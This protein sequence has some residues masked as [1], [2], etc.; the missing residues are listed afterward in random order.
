MSYKKDG[1][2]SIEDAFGGDGAAVGTVYDHGRTTPFDVIA[3][4]RNVPR[5]IVAELVIRRNRRRSGEPGIIRGDEAVARV[6]VDTQSAIGAL[7][8]DGGKGVATR[9]MK[10]VPTATVSDKPGRRVTDYP[11][12]S[13]RTRRT[14]SRL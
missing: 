12:T 5:H 1:D 13:V 8:D 6:S 7:T 9:L 4:A 11:Q 2:Y 3:T 14:S 10:D